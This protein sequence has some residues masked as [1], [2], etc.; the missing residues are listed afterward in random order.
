M[1]IYIRCIGRDST[2][3]VGAPVVIWLVILGC[4]SF[5]ADLVLHLLELRR[6]LD[7]LLSCLEYVI[8]DS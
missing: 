8:L 6:A 5:R 1:L 3:A 4:T 7:I 2:K